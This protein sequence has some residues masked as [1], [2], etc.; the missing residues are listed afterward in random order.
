MS[1]KPQLERNLNKQTKK[2]VI[3]LFQLFKPDNGGCLFKTHICIDNRLNGS[4]HDQT[5]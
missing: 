2:K 1:T 4:H 5:F 3:R